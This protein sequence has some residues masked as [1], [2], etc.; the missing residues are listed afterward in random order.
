MQS[1]PALFPLPTS[2]RYEDYYP[3]A[4]ELFES[5]FFPG[6][7]VHIRKLDGQIAKLRPKIQG[8]RRFNLDD[9]ST[10]PIMVPTPL[11]P[12]DPKPLDLLPIAGNESPN[13]VIYRQF[14]NNRRAWAHRVGKTA[15]DQLRTGGVVQAPLQFYSAN[16]VTMPNPDHPGEFW[17]GG[18]AD[19][20][21]DGDSSIPPCPRYREVRDYL[22]GDRGHEG[23]YLNEMTREMP[24]LLILQYI[25]DAHQISIPAEQWNAL[26]RNCHAN[27]ELFE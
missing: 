10:R 13:E 20:V 16:T 26:L 1:G 25:N 18:G 24:E 23:L 22:L 21:K 19:H 8:R 14:E 5:R 15:W 9:N 6:F 3:I 12:G 27:G 2:W 4:C 11:P 17:S 7:W